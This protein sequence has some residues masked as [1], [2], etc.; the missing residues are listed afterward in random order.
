MDLNMGPSI[1]FQCHALDLSHD[2]Q[3][4]E[5]GHIEEILDEFVPETERIA[6]PYFVEVEGC[7]QMKPT[8][9]LQNDGS[10]ENGGASTSHAHQ[11]NFL[12]RNLSYFLH[13][14]H[15]LVGF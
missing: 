4:S 7:C 9:N 13:H 2:V 12:S 14:H 15:F 8:I 5:D 1:C 10:E 6:H 11:S 3:E